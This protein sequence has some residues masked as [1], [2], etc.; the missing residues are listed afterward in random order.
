MG[1][2]PGPVVEIINHSPLI[3]IKSM[4]AK[5]ENENIGK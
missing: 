2:N 4:K 3:W 1:L 5:I